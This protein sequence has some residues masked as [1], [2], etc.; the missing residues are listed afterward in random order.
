MREYDI[1]LNGQAARQATRFLKILAHQGSKL[2]GAEGQNTPWLTLNG[3]R[4]LR[5]GAKF[6]SLFTIRYVIQFVI[7]PCDG[8]FCFISSISMKLISVPAHWSQVMHIYIYIY[9]CKYTYTMLYLVEIMV[10]HV[11][12]AKPLS[13]I[14]VALTLGSKFQWNLNWN[15]TMFMQENV[16]WNGVCKMMA[17]LFW[18]QCTNSL[19]PSGIIWHRRSWSTLSPVMACCL[20][21]ANC[22]L[23]QCWLIINRILWHSPESNS[24]HYCRRKLMIPLGSASK[25]VRGRELDCFLDKRSH[26]FAWLGTVFAW[27]HS[28]WSR[29]EIYI[30]LK[31]TTISLQPHLPRANELSPVTSATWYHCNLTLTQNHFIRWLNLNFNNPNHV[32]TWSHILYIL[33]TM[34]FFLNHGG[35]DWFG[36]GIWWHRPGSPSLQNKIW[37][38]PDRRTILQKFIYAKEGKLAGPTQILPVRIRG[39]ALILKTAHCWLR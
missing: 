35:L 2:K 26:C 23:H 36:D 22:Y 5:A 7:C 29:Y 27:C 25:R 3:P 4:L 17:I 16:L 39:P 31:T 12:S 15:T 38:L 32:K 9:V 14:M 21:A 24:L 11:F 18:P 19:W 6:C 1:N 20:T 10:Y 33:Q 30:S 8:H 34:I 28:K 37:N 13:E